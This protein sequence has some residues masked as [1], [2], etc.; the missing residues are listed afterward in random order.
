[1]SIQAVAAVLES[2]VGEVAAKMLLVCIANAHNTGTGVCCPSIDRLAKES[3]M[4]R[5]SVKRWLRW[6]EAEGF[7]EV[8]E[9][10]DTN[11]RQRP[12]N[13][14]IIATSR[15][16]KLNP[17]PEIEPGEGSSSE[18]L[19][20][21]NCEPALKEPEENRKKNGNAGA[22]DAVRD[23]FEKYVWADF[24]NN[25]NSNKAWAFKA[26]ASLD[27]ADRAE[28][29]RGVARLSLRFE[30]AKTDEP[31]DQRLKYHPHLSTWIKDRGWE[32]ELAV[33]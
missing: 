6:L 31:M 32:A 1:M 4:S 5:S 11:A 23:V 9:S 20:W 28:C 30:E 24:P 27:A 8:T 19:G 7:I 12:N 13:Y 3:G 10:R 2:D 22:R 26:F 18:P 29:M 33:A 14:R 16:A 17:L 15:G 25:P 21:F